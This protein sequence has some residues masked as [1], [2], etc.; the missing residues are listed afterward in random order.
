MRKKSLEEYEGISCCRCGGIVT[1]KNFNGK[2][3]WYNHKCDKEECTRHLCGKCYEK[4][5]QELRLNHN[6]IRNSLT[7]IRTGNLDKDIHSAIIDQA[8]VSKLLNID[9]LN[10]KFDNFTI[11]IDMK[12]DKL[13][14]I[15][16]KS[17]SLR[18]DNKNDI[19]YWDFHTFKKNGL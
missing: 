2:P 19:E 13:G 8:I 4:Y 16:V 9:D 15:D 11:P 10:I 14:A 17:S 7:K 1:Y 5:R 12:D 18:Y 6:A 3:L